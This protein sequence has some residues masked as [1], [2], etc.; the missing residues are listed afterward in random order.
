MQYVEKEIFEIKERNKKVE[1]DKAWEISWTRRMCIGAAVFLLAGI[2]LGLINDSYPWLKALVP[3]VG[4]IIST[5]TLPLAK[6]FWLK[7]IRRVI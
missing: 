7:N 4:Y 2:W 5:L 6:K 1:A 3:S